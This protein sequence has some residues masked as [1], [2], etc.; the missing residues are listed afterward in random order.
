MMS[1]SKTIQDWLLM[2]ELRGQTGTNERKAY[3][4]TNQLDL[5]VIYP[6]SKQFKLVCFYEPKSKTNR[7]NLFF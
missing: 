5:I 6:K 2:Y 3:T 4:R 7:I 1:S